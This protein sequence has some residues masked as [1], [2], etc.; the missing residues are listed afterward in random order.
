MANFV[1][2]VNK[3][4]N[5]GYTTDDTIEGLIDDIT[6]LLIPQSY[7]NSQHIWLQTYGK[8]Y[9]AITGFKTF[10]NHG[11][12]AKINFINELQRRYDKIKSVAEQIIIRYPKQE[13]FSVLLQILNKVKDV[14][15]HIIS[16]NGYTECEDQ[17]QHCNICMEDNHAHDN[18]FGNYMVVTDCNH[19]FH[20]GCIRQWLSVATTCPCC[21]QELH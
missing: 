2:R 9:G 5:D 11:D 14:D 4:I 18:T 3:I 7:N 8:M 16:M 12:K 19:T 15:D 1:S 20:V 13:I 10:L 17:T 6:Y 21:R